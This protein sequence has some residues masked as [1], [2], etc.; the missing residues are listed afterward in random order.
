MNSESNEHDEKTQIPTNTNRDL[1]FTVIPVQTKL[2]GIK[3]GE[4]HPGQKIYVRLN[5]EIVKH[6]PQSMREND[7][8]KKHISVPIEAEVTAIN[9]ASELPDRFSGDVDDYYVITVS[10]GKNHGGTTYA[11][12][13]TK[14]KEVVDIETTNTD[15]D[16]VVIGLI[17]LLLFLQ[18]LIIYV[19]FF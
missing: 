15:T 7:E 16:S 14:I 2:E 4:L 5:G 3:G 6:M 10:F 13:N 8:P 9:S 19:Y 17:G 11:H 12:K 18:L 1:D